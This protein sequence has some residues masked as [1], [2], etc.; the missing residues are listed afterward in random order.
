[1]D[2]NY[3]LAN[4]AFQYSDND[5][6][7]FGFVRHGEKTAFEYVQRRNEHN[8]RL[9]KEKNDAANKKEHR[10]KRANQIISQKSMRDAENRGIF[11]AIKQLPAH[12]QIEIIIDDPNYQVL[13]YMPVI[14][15][16]LHREEVEKSSWLLLLHRFQEMD[17]TPFNLR[18][19]KVIKEKIQ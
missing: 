17:A 13:Y 3:S 4:W 9:L 11:E 12:Q 7:P 2:N 5:Y 18:M 14:S 6:I 16:L 8:R 1:M 10:L 15:T 19:I